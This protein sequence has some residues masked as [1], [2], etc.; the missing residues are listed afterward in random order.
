VERNIEDCGKPQMTI[1]R[2]R[3]ACWITKATHTLTVC[4]IYCFSTTTIVVRTR[5]IVT[6]YVHCM[7]RLHWSNV[8]VRF[9]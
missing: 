5:L 4:N 2:M 6:L 1:W 9:M 7:S 8:G 3:I